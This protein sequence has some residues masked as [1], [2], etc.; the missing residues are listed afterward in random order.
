M[1][2]KIELRVSLQQ[3]VEIRAA[4]GRAELPQAGGSGAGDRASLQLRGHHRHR[5][6]WAQRAGGDLEGKTEAAWRRQRGRGGQGGG[7]QMVG[8]HWCRG[9]Q[10]NKD[11]QVLGTGDQG[12]S[13][14][15]AHVY[16]AQS[17]PLENGSRA[18]QV[19]GPG[20]SPLLGRW[21]P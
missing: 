20:T 6:G 8:G 18:R 9:Q 3:L 19:L 15:S 5:H 13:P 11:K 17:S 14:S 21:Q 7:A 1:V 16:E 10:S 12:S 4:P 2:R